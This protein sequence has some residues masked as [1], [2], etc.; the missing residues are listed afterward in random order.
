MGYTYNCDGCHNRYDSFPPFA[1][2]FTE[3]F[4]KTNGGL[5]AQEFDP[6]QKITICPDCMRNLVLTPG[7]SA[8]DVADASEFESEGHEVKQ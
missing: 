7:Q 8:A 1:G 3:A 2:E 6:G 4:L 5:F